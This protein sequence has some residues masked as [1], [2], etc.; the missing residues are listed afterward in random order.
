MNKEILIELNIDQTFFP[1]VV[2]AKRLH[3]GLSHSDY[4]KQLHCTESQLRAAESGEAFLPEAVVE[5]FLNSHNFY[6]LTKLYLMASSQG[7]GVM[8]VKHTVGPRVFKQVK[9]VFTEMEY[10]VLE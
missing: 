9:E 3:N 8:K 7:I 1:R 10:T 2:K 4:A 5:H 6:N